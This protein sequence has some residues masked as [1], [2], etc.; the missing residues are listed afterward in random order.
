MKIES[1]EFGRIRI[2][3]KTYINDLIIFPDH[4]EDDWWRKRGHELHKEDIGTIMEEAPEVL[5]V[6]TGASGYLNVSSEIKKFIESKGIKVKIAKSREACK[7]F[8]ELSEKRRVVAAFHL[9]C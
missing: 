6:G 2:D 8:N 1:Y 3:G 4:V 5:I 7:L 9:T